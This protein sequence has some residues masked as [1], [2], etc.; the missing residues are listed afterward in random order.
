MLTAKGYSFAGTD[1][2][3]RLHGVELKDHDSRLR[4]TYV[5][6]AGSVMLIE[7]SLLAWPITATAI[8]RLQAA[9]QWVWFLYLFRVFLLLWSILTSG[10]LAV[11][12][13]WGRGT[14][15]WTSFYRVYASFSPAP[16]LAGW[17]TLAFATGCVLGGIATVV[18][19][20]IKPFYTSNLLYGL[21][22]GIGF[23][24]VV[25]SFLAPFVV[26]HFGVMIPVNRARRI[27]LEKMHATRYTQYHTRK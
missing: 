24:M 2:R 4:G 19:A 23:L 12:K 16:A 22:I 18:S 8:W 6:V 11:E 25:E 5:L 10:T 15:N 1:T 7:L 17:S 9:V 26:Y 14:Y 3:H 13:L 20:A 27:E 21:A